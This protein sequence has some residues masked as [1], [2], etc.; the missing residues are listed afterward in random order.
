[1]AEKSEYDYFLYRKENPDTNYVGH[2]FDK[3][4]LN[5]GIPESN[6]WVKRVLVTGEDAGFVKIDGE[7]VLR[8]SPTG[9]IQMKALIYTIGNTTRRGLT[10]QKF[11]ET[12][13]GVLNPRVELSF[14]FYNEEWIELL[15]FLDET[16]FID[17]AN[18]QA[19]KIK[20]NRPD[21]P[22]ELPSSLANRNKNDDVLK[23]LEGLSGEERI[24]LV[25]LARNGLFSKIELDILSGRIDGLKLFDNM[26][27]NDNM[28]V[29]E[30][31]WQKF[32]EKESWILGYGLDYRFLQILQREAS[33]SNSTLNGT[34]TVITD[35]LTT[36][37]RFTT[38]VE[39]KKPDTKLFGELRNRSRSWKLSDQLTESVSQILAQKA[40]WQ[41]KSKVANYTKDGTKISERTVDP[42]AILIIGHTQQFEGNDF[43]SDIKAETFE[44][45]RR[46]L[47]SVEIIT[48]DEL[49]ERA[50]FI[51]RNT[52]EESQPDDTK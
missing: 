17:L 9:A 1:M 51:V 3:K 23:D 48:Y 42:K 34:D 5:N 19:F 27:I 4:F 20:S 35:F 38:I 14:T 47:R 39:L 25:H 8:I 37:T 31:D 6:R 43:E 28:S 45:Y 24:K 26:L 49:F 33:V 40:E 46:N 10:I 7:I 21:N 2:R 36:D 29:N 22:I 12:R 11:G 50:K 44:I 18:K 30:I 32:L 41:L 13:K 52:S 15:K 16:K